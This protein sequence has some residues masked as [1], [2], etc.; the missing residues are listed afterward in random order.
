M[1]F[2]VD[3]L[4]KFDIYEN[5]PLEVRKEMFALIK[6]LYLRKSVHYNN[7]FGVGQILDIIIDRYDSRDHAN[8]V[9]NKKYEDNAAPILGK[10]NGS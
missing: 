4:W 10:F 1:Q 3:F 8:I 7:L 9:E 5:A 6:A 2:F